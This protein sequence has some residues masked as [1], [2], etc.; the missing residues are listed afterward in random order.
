[1][2]ASNWE[3]FNG[4]VRWRGTWSTGGTYLENDIVKNNVSS[5]IC[6][7]EHTAA[8]TFVDDL[9]AGKWQL[10]AEGGDYVIPT[11]TEMLK[12]DGQGGVEPATAGTTYLAPAAIGTTVQAYDGN[13]PTFPA[14]IS[15]TEIGYLNGVS[16]SIQTQIDGKASLS[17]ATFTG[18]VS[19][20]TLTLS[21][22][23]T[24]NGTTT[25]VNSTQLD[26]SDKNIT[27]ASGAA[28]AAA[29]NGAGLTVD[30]AAATIIYTSTTDTWDFNKPI[31]GSYTNLHPETTA[32]TV[33][34]TATVSL[35]EPVHLVTLSAATTI[36]VSDGSL[37]RTSMMYLDT[38]AS[39]FTPTFSN[40][41]W[42]DGTE[43]S[44]AGNRYWL[45]SM[46]SQGGSVVLASATGHA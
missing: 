39:G 6:V 23:L 1:L 45:I 9:T 11:T 36:S 46:F 3:K 2:A 16:S 34:S 19:G 28:D 44:W 33:S 38:S 7:E 18:A 22:N 25:T 43:P 42:P 30:G 32:V 17:G 20:T 14:G 15:S 31:S 12:G 41:S 21:G 8:L 35:N 13:L 4:G 37:G 26:V 29:A 10:M 5:Y 24:V 27:I 40:F